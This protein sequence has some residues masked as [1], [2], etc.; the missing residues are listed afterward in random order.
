MSHESIKYIYYSDNQSATIRYSGFQV[1]FCFVCCCF[2]VL[3]FLFP[4]VLFY[5]SN[6][7]L[8]CGPPPRS[9]FICLWRIEQGP[10]ISWSVAQLPVFVWLHV[11]KGGHSQ[12]MCLRFRSA[13]LFVLIFGK[14]LNMAETC[15]YRVRNVTLCIVL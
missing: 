9:H 8:K 15:T 5:G 6:K 2:F 14:V 1:C 10:E 11:Y 4:K 3:G 13:L 12:E 7:F